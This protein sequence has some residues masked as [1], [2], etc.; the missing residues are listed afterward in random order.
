VLARLQVGING[1]LPTYR[2][3]QSRTNLFF[4]LLQPQR[5]HKLLQHHNDLRSASLQLQEALLSY[6]SYQK[7]QASGK[8]VHQVRKFPF[9]WRPPAAHHPATRRHQHHR[10]PRPCDQFALSGHCYRIVATPQVTCSLSPSS[11]LAPGP[12]SSRSLVAWVAVQRPSTST[13]GFF[14][15]ALS[16][17][18]KSQITCF[19]LSPPCSSSSRPIFSRPGSLTP[20]LST[21]SQFPC[22][23]EHHKILE[24]CQWQQANSFTY[25]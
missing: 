13:K 23:H 3:F 6:N 1:G 5:E 15:A 20:S 14:A 18:F 9:A 19:L 21:S 2:N 7:H 16:H 12:I 10:I 17:V 8:L 11:S 4:Y 25:R 24:T 22:T